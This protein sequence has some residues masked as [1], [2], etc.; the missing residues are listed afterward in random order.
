MAPETLIRADGQAFS[1][2]YQLVV[3]LPSQQGYC[4]DT[5]EQNCQEPQWI[6]ERSNLLMFYRQSLKYGK[7]ESVANKLNENN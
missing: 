1:S 4:Q 7:E 5:T 6:S 2:L 3:D